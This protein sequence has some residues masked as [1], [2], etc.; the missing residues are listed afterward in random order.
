MKAVM[1]DRETLYRLLFDA[2]LDLRTEGKECRNGR[3]FGLADLMHQLP[4]QLMEMEEGKLQATDILE[5][6]RSHAQKRGVETWLEK[7][8]QVSSNG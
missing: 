4:N 6:L 8:L 1:T 7:H 3:V 5:E 2:L